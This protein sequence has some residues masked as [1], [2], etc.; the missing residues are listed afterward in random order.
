MQRKP[1][2]TGN[3]LDDFILGAKDEKTKVLEPNQ[4]NKKQTPQDATDQDKPKRQTY[5][6]EPLYI[7]A[8][9]QMAF[10]EKMDKSE[11]VR[12]AIRQ[13]VPSKYVNLAVKK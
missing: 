5:Y 6:I 13:Y 1:I 10:Y 4:P 7:E 9:E 12:Q 2:T 3:N 11:I 8:I